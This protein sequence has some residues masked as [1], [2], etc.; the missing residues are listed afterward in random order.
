MQL[1]EILEENTLKAISK[2]TNISQDNLEALF[3]GDFSHL[4]KTKAFGFLSILER[5]YHTDVSKLREQATEYYAQHK[6]EEGRMIVH[7]SEVPSKP[8]KS[9]WFLFAVAALFIY[10]SW[11]F[12][13]QFDKAHL[14]G[15]LPFSEKKMGSESMV[16]EINVSEE[17]SIEKTIAATQEEQNVSQQGLSEDIESNQTQT[18][19][20]NVS[21]NSEANSTA[22]AVLGE[23][24]TL[25]TAIVPLKQ[26]WFGIID[27]QTGERKNYLIAE[28]YP[29]ATDDKSWLIATSPAAFSL[30]GDKTEMKFN[31]AK[32]HYF[33]IDKDGIQQ[34]TKNEYVA[35]GG[36][37]KW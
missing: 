34:L 6:E 26:L 37:K 23:N 14:T 32:R 13:T 33:K 15:I 8:S 21:Q 25:Q 12:F 35:M 30:V 7:L 11:Y 17:L 24:Q 29:L 20:A 31:D 4:Q 18:E 9:K 2:K 36:W 16:Q 19:E 10:A 28:K 1:N 5:E 27:M 22:E 3:A